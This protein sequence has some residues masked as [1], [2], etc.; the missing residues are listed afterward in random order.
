MC[1]Y[2]LSEASI[3]FYA[4]AYLLRIEAQQ[5]SFQISARLTEIVSIL[6]VTQCIDAE[7][8]FAQA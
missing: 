4:F 1:T 3:L 6:A 8:A 7:A 5:D 2:L